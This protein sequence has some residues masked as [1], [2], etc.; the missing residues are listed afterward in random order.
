MPIFLHQSRDRF[1]LPVKGHPKLIR[2]LERR[3]WISRSW[4][5]CI[6]ILAGGN[7]SSR[8][9]VDPIVNPWDVAAVMPVVTEAAGVLT[10][11]KGTPASKVKNAVGTNGHLHAESPV[12]LE[13]VVV[14]K[15]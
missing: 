13:E 4:E 11:W 8:H 10:D 2:N 12:D 6:R 3:C 15:L 7:R 9:H 14:F 1:V 5:G